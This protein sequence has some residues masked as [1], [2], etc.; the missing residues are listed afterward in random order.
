MSTRHNRWSVLATL[1]SALLIASCST[2]DPGRVTRNDP[3]P[4]WK[5]GAGA[6][7]A[8][9]FMKIQVPSGATEVKGAVQVNPQEDSYILTFRTDSATAAQIAKD[10]RSE[11][12]PAPWKSSSSPKR[13][14]FR[15][16]GLAEPQ[17]LK[18]PLRA[19]VCPPCV[20]DDRRR[21]VAWM[22]IYIENLSSEQAR[23]Y[24]HAF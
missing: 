10:L 16:L 23:V 19:S 18:A 6:A 12:P 1:F 9:G 15:H 22:E 2:G 5:K 8:A 14:L 13:E 21:K 3:Y 20:E 7:E 17:T 11:D 24:L 4:Y